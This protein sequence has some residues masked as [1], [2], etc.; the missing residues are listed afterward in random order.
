MRFISLSTILVRKE[1]P[2]KINNHAQQPPWRGAPWGVGPNAAASVA[3]AGPANAHRQS[4][5]LMQC[6]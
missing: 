6:L 1:Y 4:L 3:S 5:H 2:A